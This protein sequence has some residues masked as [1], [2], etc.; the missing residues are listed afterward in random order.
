MC[1]VLVL[2]N[3]YYNLFFSW[4]T[5]KVIYT[6]TLMK[7]PVEPAPE[8]SELTDDYRRFDLDSSLN[9]QPKGLDDH[10]RPTMDDT[11]HFPNILISQM[12]RP[13]KINC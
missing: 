4:G 6:G 5:E 2:I 10:D 7:P 12:V 8:K 3:I 1:F 11:G 13:R 9:A